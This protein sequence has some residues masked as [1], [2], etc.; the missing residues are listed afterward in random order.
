[1]VS[2][3][4]ILLGSGSGARKTEEVCRARRQRSVN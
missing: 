4:H 2:N 3:M 1:L